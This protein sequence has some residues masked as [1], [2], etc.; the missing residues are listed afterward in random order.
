LRLS[1]AFPVPTIAVLIRTVGRTTLARAIH[2]VAMQ[3]HP[4]VVVVMVDARGDLA[5]WIPANTQPLETSLARRLRDCACGDWPGLQLGYLGSEILPL[6]WP[7]LNRGSTPILMVSCGVS[8]LRSRAAEVALRVGSRL[9]ASA[10]F[11]DDDDEF[12]PDHLSSLSAALE[13]DPEA[14]ASHTAAW[15]VSATHQGVRERSLGRCFEPWELLHSN[16]I[17]IHCAMFRTLAVAKAEVGFDDHLEVFEDWDFWLQLQCLGR[18][19]WVEGTTALYNLVETEM[20]S[21]VHQIARNAAAY[22]WIWNKWRYRAPGHWWN[23]LLEH[24]GPLVEHLDEQ[25]LTNAALE[26]GNRAL[27]HALHTEVEENKSLHERLSRTEARL[28]EL[29][30]AGRQSELKREAEREDRNLAHEQDRLRWQQ[31]S[32]TL[33]FQVASLQHQLNAMY[34]SRSWRVTQPLRAAANIGRCSFVGNLVRKLPRFRSEGVIAGSR[35]RPEATARSFP[36]PARET[37]L[38]VLPPQGFRSYQDWIDQCEAPL[39]EKR[40]LELDRDLDSRLTRSAQP[41]LADRSPDPGGRPLNDGKLPLISIV[42]PLFNPPEVFLREAIDS[43]LAQRYT[44]WELCLADD[45]SSERSGLLFVRELTQRDARIRLIERNENGHISACSN[46]ALSLTQ[47]D[48]VVLMDQDDLLSPF[49]LLEVVAALRM[50]PNA[51]VLYSDEDKIDG[52]GKRFDPYFKPAFN[53]ELLR[54]QNM[55]SHLGVYS[56]SLLDAVGGF[57]AGMEGS[58]DHDLAL[59]CVERIAE[60]QVIHIPHVLYHWRVHASST[61]SDAAV[62]PYA[63]VNGLSAVND[64]LARSV[65]GANAVIHRAIPHY[66]VRYP[67]PEVLPALD[68]I[69]PTRNGYDLIKRCLKTLFDLTRYPAMQVV[70]VDNGSDDPRVLALLAQYQTDCAIQVIRHDGPFNFSR[71]NNLA[72]AAC[73]AP[74]ILF[75]NNDVEIVDE[76]WLEE[77]VRQAARPEVGAVGAML[78]YPGYTMQHAGVV[79][80]AGGVAGHAHHR[81]P[82]GNAGYFGR[83]MLAHE[84]SAATAACLLLRREVFGQAGGFDEEALAVAFND[85]DLCLRVRKLGYKVIF[86]PCAELIHHESATRGD[87]LAPERRDRFVHECAVMRERWLGVI[88]N[89]PGYNPNLE[90]MRSTFQGYAA[91][92]NPNAR[93]AL[94]PV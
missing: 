91:S 44:N 32:D 24:L 3:Q 90:C 56:K 94:L 37:P 60:G 47:G 21:Q 2:S 27:G 31:R 76:V 80:G 66:V 36:D 50:F 34:A 33:L 17:P 6:A 49:A 52:K 16:Y 23:A 84:V 69:V 35:R 63:L 61:A 22:H 93:T 58:Q 18:F 79:V 46:S 51:C 87:D 14:I 29:E 30:H 85:V 57:R 72:V 55:I 10:I 78:W 12:L 86:T 92:R 59:R 39:L 41:P 43:V 88:N 70:V 5:A 7:I 65:P 68:V 83:A 20:P 11:L 82:R 74:Y 1:P 42:M 28:L 9:C 38:A 4:G 77:L 15:L 73:H 67:L 26:A 8:L 53:L 71:I 89:D 62:K 48:W 25:R 81:L 13:S 54:A 75:L 19:R 45:A 40:A 64:H